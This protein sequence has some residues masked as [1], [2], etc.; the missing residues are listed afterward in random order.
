MRNVSALAL[1][2]LLLSATSTLA[3]EVTGVLVDEACYIKEKAAGTNSQ[4]KGEDVACAQSCAKSGNSVALVT[5]KGEVY[6][7]MAMGALAG[8][9]NAK[10]VPHMTHKVV[11]TGDLVDGKDGKK[12]IHATA[13]K[14]VK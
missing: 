10:L 5:D 13:L 1:G 8:D 2:L 12:M 14:M 7:V 4:L 11:L 6:Q 9:K 3:A